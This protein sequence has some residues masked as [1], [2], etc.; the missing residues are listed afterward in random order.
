ML[1]SKACCRSLQTI[2]CFSLGKNSIAC[3]QNEQLDFAYGD[4]DGVVVLRTKSGLLP[5]PNGPQPE[6]LCQI[7]ASRRVEVEMT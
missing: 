7:T 2:A 5:K 6:N 4:D 3:W 1:E